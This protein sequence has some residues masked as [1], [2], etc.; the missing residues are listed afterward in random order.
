MPTTGLRPG[1]QQVAE[2]SQL[3]TNL[4]GAVVSPAD[5]PDGSSGLLLG[6]GAVSPLLSFDSELALS[7]LSTL[8]WARA[9]PGSLAVQLVA[10]AQPSKALLDNQLFLR[11]AFALPLVRV[12]PG[13]C[14]SAAA[15]LGQR[16]KRPYAL[17]SYVLLDGSTTDE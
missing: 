13:R 8:A 5:G 16:V 7:L 6:S 12:G 1:G 17:L 15:G 11:I 4:S 3:S 9:E 14:M 10:I 2:S